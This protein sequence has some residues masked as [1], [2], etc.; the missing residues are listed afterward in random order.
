MENILDMKT[1]Q[2]NVIIGTLFKEQK[3]KPNVFTNL[4]GPIKEIDTFECSVSD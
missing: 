2:L 1:N 3:N 4:T